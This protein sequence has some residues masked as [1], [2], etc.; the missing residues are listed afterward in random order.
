MPIQ[1]KLMFGLN[2]QSSIT[3]WIYK[4]VLWGK[5][6]F[7]FKGNSHSEAFWRARLGSTGWRRVLS[8]CRKQN[9]K[10]PSFSPW[11]Q[12]LHANMFC[13]GHLAYR[14]TAFLNVCKMFSSQAHVWA[15]C[16]ILSHFCVFIL[17]SFGPIWIG[18]EH[19]DVILTVLYGIWQWFFKHAH[20][21]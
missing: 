4:S 9:R 2:I 16:A 1:V 18:C 14:S 3:L 7:F 19:S 15:K 10:A 6:L 11:T 20:Y 17:F 5:F 12:M 13:H 21:V 8:Y